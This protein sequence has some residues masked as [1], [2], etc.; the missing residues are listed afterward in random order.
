MQKIETEFNNAGVLFLLKLDT[1]LLQGVAN[2]AEVG[3]V[4]C[5]CEGCGTSCATGQRSDDIPQG[6][7]S[8]L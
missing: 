6:V 8:A 2:F 1:G 7:W 4:F 3:F 5:S